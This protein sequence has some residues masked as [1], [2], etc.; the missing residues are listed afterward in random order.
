QES[1]KGYLPLVDAQGNLKAL[2]TRTDLRKN[3]ENPMANK[4]VS[5]KLLVGAAVRAG[6][7]DEIDHYRIECLAE[8]GANVIVLEAQ[9]GDSDLQVQ[10]IKYIKSNFPG[11]D[12]VAGNVVRSSQAKVLLEAGADGLRVGMGAGSVA[13]TQLVKA[14]G[15]AQLSAI[16][17]CARMARSYGVPVIADGG[18]KNTGCIIKALS[19]GA[20]VVMMGHMLA[21]VDESPGEYIFQNG[22]R[23]KNYRANFTG[24]LLADLQASPSLRGSPIRKSAGSPA[25]SRGK[26]LMS[27]D[28]GAPPANR[29]ASGV[30]ARVTENGPVSRYLPYLCQSIR[31]GMQDMGTCSVS[32]LHEQ[33]YAGRVRFEL[34]STSAQKEGGVHD[35]HSFSQQLYA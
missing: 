21:G 11:I 2:T 9:N 5:G 24:P 12:V 20:S 17:A 26:A 7:Y 4:D 18:I 29:V 14:V 1:K 33:L 27:G 19:I 3:K 6:A 31:H 32:A 10:Y 16:Y 35:L 15:R 25:P 34:R 23:L 22:I 28:S 8:A 30:S 13:T